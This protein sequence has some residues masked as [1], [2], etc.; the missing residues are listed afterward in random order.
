MDQQ[1]IDSI[2]AQGQ[3]RRAE[4]IS[5]C[6]QDLARK[7]KQL[8]QLQ[9][10]ASALQKRQG[11]LKAEQELFES[12]LLDKL[13][14]EGAKA[15]RKVKLRNTRWKKESVLAVFFSG[16]LPCEMEEKNWNMYAPESLSEDRD[17]LLARVGRAEFLNHYAFYSPSSDAKP[18]RI[19][20][21][22]LGDKEVVTAVVH[23]YPEVL[24]QD[25][26]PMEIL[27]DVD[28]FYAYWNSERRKY[29]LRPDG[30]D[31]ALRTE[32]KRFE[33][34]LARFGTEIRGSAEL[35]LKAA[36][37]IHHGAIFAHFS[38][39]LSDDCA[40]ALQLAK[41]TKQV[42]ENALERFSDRVK[43]H[44]E[45]V[46]SLVQKNGI[47]LKDAD[48]ALKSD[49]AVVGAA[50][51]ENAVAILHCAPGPIQQSLLR[52]KDFLLDIFSRW[53]RWNTEFR[54]RGVELYNKL[55]GELKLDHDIVIHA[56]L[57]ECLAV[58]DFPTELTGD[59]EFWMKLIK[60]DSSVWSKLPEE[61]ARDPTFARA[62][63]WFE[64]KQLFEDVVRR[65][66]FLLEERTFWSTVIESGCEIEEILIDLLHEHLPERFLRDKELML[67]GCRCEPAVLQLLPVELQQDRD[68]FE[69]VIG[70]N[71]RYIPPEPKPDA[72]KYI[73]KSVQ[74]IYPNLTVQAISNLIEGDG[75]VSF[76]GVTDS[77]VALVAESLWENLQI[78][79]AWFEI[80]GELHSHFPETMKDNREFGL[81]VAKHHQGFETA[82][83]VALRSDKAYMMKAVE[84]DCTLFI[85][86]HG[87]M[88]KD[89]D[90]AVLA[91]SDVNYA[92]LVECIEWAGLVDPEA[93]DQSDRDLA[94][95]R[96]VRAKAK[97]K[98]EA[99]GGFT[100]AFV[101]GMTDFAGSGCHLPLLVRDKE[102]CLGLKRL[103]A[104]FLDVPTGKEVLKLR[105]VVENLEGIPLRCRRASRS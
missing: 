15:W 33:K 73:P 46:L 78:W 65:F 102:T 55:L 81:L 14:K 66:P 5:Q 31:Y 29:L 34:L 75:S 50:C 22:L 24:L 97:A 93:A 98:V 87:R 16:K 70:P 2:L 12:G 8:R 105:R 71:P 30:K 91:C 104:D 72:L 94:F 32:R 9:K 51:K 28:L 61:Y 85:A 63:L 83:S 10:E 80:G 58:S 62:I 84:T 18:F 82:A 77:H 11:F 59:R 21:A 1:R 56:Y 27:D 64:E 20:Q 41:L 7:Q 49:V 99:H 38:V 3:K 53:P 6:T 43:A 48:K 89:F 74:V 96:S 57:M 68:L 92:E 44:R 86:A 95:L 13:K 19:P 67:A 90:L 69:A 17:V 60:Q 100:E 101:Y 40:F 54:G 35:L 25:D 4:E 23:R 36:P 26:I 39:E 103:I 45:V 79:E 42:P 88:R 37:N 47:C 52:D 76:H